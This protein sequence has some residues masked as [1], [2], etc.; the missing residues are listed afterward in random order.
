MNDKKMIYNIGRMIPVDGGKSPEAA[1][2]QGR[3]RE[4]RERFTQLVKG[5]FSSVMKISAL[6]LNLRDCTDRVSGVS[7]NLRGV[8]TEVVETA[9]ITEESMNEVVSVH[10]SFNEN[11]QQVAEAAAEIRIRWGRAARSCRSLP[12]VQKKPYTIP[13]R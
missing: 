10:E 13:M 3:L 8:V 2:L 1:Q 6:D 7:N 12:S 11:I 4:G 9:R 5:V